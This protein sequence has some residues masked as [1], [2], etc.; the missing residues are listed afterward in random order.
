MTDF[1]ADLRKG[2]NTERLTPRVSI[3]LIFLTVVNISL[4]WLLSKMLWRLSN[5]DRIIIL[6]GR[7]LT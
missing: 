4:D 2:E 5:N 1:G 6:H 3:F 7:T